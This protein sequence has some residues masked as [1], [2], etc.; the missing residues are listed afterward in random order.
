[1][2]RRKTSKERH[3]WSYRMKRF[4][5]RFEN[6]SRN[7]IRQDAVII[8]IL[9]SMT[10]ILQNSARRAELPDAL[11]DRVGVCNFPVPYSIWSGTLTYPWDKPTQQ[12]FKM[13]AADLRYR[14]NQLYTVIM[15][16]SD[17]NNNSS[18]LT[19]SL[20]D[21]GGVGGEVGEG[22]SV[23][24]SDVEADLTGL[25]SANENY[26]STI[27]QL[28]AGALAYLLETAPGTPVYDGDLTQIR[29]GV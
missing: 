28:T 8:R 1:M 19:S 12:A 18:L 13:L 22:S 25:I 15:D 16:T 23:V 11:V 17:H 27:R 5:T 9:A 21:G 29:T 26:H 4:E 14:F 7:F 6:S 2:D 3:E 24:I 20:L 10:Q